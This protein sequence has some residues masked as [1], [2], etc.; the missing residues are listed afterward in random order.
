[1]VFHGEAILIACTGLAAWVR[2]AIDS[3]SAEE[4]HREFVVAELGD[5]P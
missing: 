4:R 5:T 1:M 3:L 2:P